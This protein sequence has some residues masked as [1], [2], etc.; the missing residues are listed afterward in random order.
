MLEVLVALVL[1][2]TGL[3]IAFTAISGSLRVTEKSNGHAAA[4]VLARSKLDEAL[5][6]P[7]FS[8]APDNGETSF[9]GVAF[10][11]RLQAKPIPLLT[12]AQQSR[13]PGVRGQFEEVNVEVFWGPEGAKQSYVLRTW[14]FLSAP[15]PTRTGPGALQ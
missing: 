5:A 7:N 13:V 9:A 4:M 6:S 10:G 12:A 3:A 14:R 11:Y 15:A 8:V 2:G 1:V